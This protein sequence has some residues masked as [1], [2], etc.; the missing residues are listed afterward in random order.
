MFKKNKIDKYRVKIKDNIWIKMSD[1]IKLSAKIWFPISKSS[2]S[3]P[4]I[5][6]FIPYRKGDA[7][8]IRDFVIHQ[9]Y[10]ENG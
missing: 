5:L 2:P 8:S 9:F 6:E 1:G 3:L 10:A 4:T 7:Y